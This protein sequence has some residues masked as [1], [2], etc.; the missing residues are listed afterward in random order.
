MIKGDMVELME[1]MTFYKK[2][3][4]AT[5]IRYEKGNSN[6]VELAWIGEENAHGDVEVVPAK[7]L[8]I[9]L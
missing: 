7:Y 8:K 3:R 4:R 2:G 5:F 1:D 6:N 9:S